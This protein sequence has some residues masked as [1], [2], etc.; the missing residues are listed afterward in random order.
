MAV[1]AEVPPARQ[2]EARECWAR[3][4]AGLARRFG[5]ALKTGQTVREHHGRG[6]GFATLLPP[7]AVLSARSSGT[8]DAAGDLPLAETLGS[9]PQYL[10]NLP[11][12]QP[13]LRHLSIVF[14][15]KKGPRVTVGCPTS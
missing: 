10:S 12:G 15:N 4:A 14:R 13:L 11:H 5:D 9:K 3:A 8:A 7:D 6:V 1:S 2:T